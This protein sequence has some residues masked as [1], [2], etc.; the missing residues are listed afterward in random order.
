MEY[1][2]QTVP[3]PLWLY[4]ISFLF[5]GAFF[6]AIGSLRDIYRARRDR[7]EALLELD[8]LRAR[9]GMPPRNEQDLSFDGGDNG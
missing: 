5:I 9:H 3:L 7:K 6:V 8:D 4:L 2:L 1:R